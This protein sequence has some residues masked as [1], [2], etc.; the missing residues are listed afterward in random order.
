MYKKTRTNKNIWQIMMK[1]FM[2]WIYNQTKEYL[3]YLHVL[4]IK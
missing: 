3:Y 2:K 1:Y 4:A